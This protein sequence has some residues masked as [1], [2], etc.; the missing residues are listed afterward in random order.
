MS[1]MT[2]AIVTISG[3]LPEDF[4]ITD[5]FREPFLVRFIYPHH[6]TTVISRQEFPFEGHRIHIRPWRLEDGAEQVNLCQH[7]RQCIES[8][9][10]YAWTD[11][12][13]HQVIGWAFSLYY[14]ED[15]F[16]HREYTKALCL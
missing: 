8:L 12:A 11:M 1:I 6:R 4:S 5:H 7:V 14:I 9:P 10:M 3:V 13:A 16:K 15:R 2:H